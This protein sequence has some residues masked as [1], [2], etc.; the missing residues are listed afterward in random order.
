MSIAYFIVVDNDNPGF[1]TFVDGKSLA[2]EASR[3]DS[4]CQKLGIPTFGNFLSTSDD[5]LA[6]ILGEDIEL[7]EGEEEQ[8]FSPEEGISF[9]NALAAHIKEN[10]KA[11]KNAEGVLSDLA[12]YAEVLEKARAAGAKWHLSLDI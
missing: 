8:W 2:R 12:D 9:V 6:D 5:D 3:L 7:P 10:P 11:V 1:D 4:V